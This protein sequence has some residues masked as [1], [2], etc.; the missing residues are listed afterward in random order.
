MSGVTVDEKLHE[1]TCRQTVL[2]G[3]D[4]V[5]VPRG[6]PMAEGDDLLGWFGEPGLKVVLPRPV[7]GPEDLPPGLMGTLDTAIERFHDVRQD[8][9]LA[10]PGEPEDLGAA[11]VEEG[12][13]VEGLG[14]W[15]FIEGAMVVTMDTDDRL[16]SPRAI[17]R[18]AILLVAALEPYGP[19]H[20]TGASES[21][22]SPHGDD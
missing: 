4:V 9:R 17:D 6:E 8:G 22:H 15:E 14:G 3:S 5:E 20:I 11:P 10:E 18:M 12:L 21:D 1:V 2:R 7:H 13:V 16:A 19:A